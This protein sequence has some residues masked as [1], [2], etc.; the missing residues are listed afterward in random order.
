MGAVAILAERR[1]RTALRG[2]STVRA[3]AVLGRL[4]F[5]FVADV[6]IHLVLDGAAGSNVGRGTAGVALHAGEAGMARAGQFSRI[7]VQRTLSSGVC[8]LQVGIGVA[9]HA[10][11]VGHP[12]RVVDPAGLV[13][14]VTVDT[15]RNQVRLLLPQLAADHLAMHLLDVRVALG[16]RFG[17][18]CLG[19]RG[20]GIGVRKHVVRGMA[21][22]ANGGNGQ[23]LLEEADTM[24]AVLVILRN[25]GLRDGAR[26]ANFA[27]LA[28]TGAAKGRNVDGGD[29]GLQI[30]WRQDVM[31][32]CAD[33]AE[34]ASRSIGVILRR[35]FPMDT[36][37]ILALLL[38][39]AQAA[40]DR[41]QLFRMRHLFDIAVARD[42]FNGGMGGRFQ[43]ARVE[44]RRYAC[45]ALSGSRGGSMAAGTV[46]GMQLCRLLAAKAGGQDGRNGSEPE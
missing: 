14:L 43:G 45:L 27:V 22:G 7:D 23:A 44:T 40:I 36:A 4:L 25:V 37:A 31:R 46:V 32:R 41:S 24:D 11:A 9:T 18:V 5:M 3:L 30:G 28:V 20:P 12:F 16:T 8:P 13:R 10:I 2:Q 1:V 21:T 42:A 39:V 34:F 19:D 6:A 17:D 15:R 38:T 33:M 35:L 29:L 26:L